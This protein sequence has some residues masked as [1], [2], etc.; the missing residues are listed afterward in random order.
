[1]DDLELG[2]LPCDVRESDCILCM[3]SR[4]LLKEAHPGTAFPLLLPALF[5]FS[6]LQFLCFLQQWYRKDRAKS[7]N[8]LVSSPSVATDY[9]MYWTSSTRKKINKLTRS[10]ATSQSKANPEPMTDCIWHLRKYALAGDLVC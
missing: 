8:N 1:M 2:C 9:V 7:Q 3:C 6:V 10:R 4:L 5:L